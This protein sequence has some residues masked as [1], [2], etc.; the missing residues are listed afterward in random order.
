MDY[1][2]TYDGLPSRALPLTTR[3]LLRYASRFHHS[4]PIV[5]YNVS[6]YQGEYIDSICQRYTW[7]TLY[8][9]C[10]QL[11]ETLC[12]KWEF[13]Y[14]WYRRLGT[15]HIVGTLLTNSMNH[16]EIA[17][18]VTSAGWIFCP[19]NPKL[20]IESLSYC[21]RD[22]QPKAIFYELAFQ[23][24][25]DV[26]QKRTDTNEGSVEWICVDNVYEHLIDASTGTQVKWPYIDEDTPA[27]LCFSSGT[28][29]RPRGVL[30]SHR[31]LV[32]A[33]MTSITPDGIGLRASDV[34]LILP[35]F[36][37]ACAWN[38]LWMCSLTGCKVVL[39]DDYAAS[40]SFL[41][42]LDITDCP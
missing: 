8:Q 21:I 33:S 36:Y 26:I 9:R 34:L 39:V 1:Q 24:I 13:D 29:S 10:S 27:T 12:D 20:D 41:T 35:G 32:I 42:I 18:T 2:F 17:Y 19:F 25:V 38:L 5:S 40:D 31:D 7:N 28:T 22:S 15:K 11:Y 37:H 3:E 30:Q 4:T 16:L 6:G 14:R 23:S